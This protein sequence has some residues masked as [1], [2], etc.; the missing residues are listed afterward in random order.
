MQIVENLEYIAERKKTD[1]RYKNFKF[2]AYLGRMI[3]LWH[4]LHEYVLSTDVE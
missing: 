2:R 1:V 3:D 4:S